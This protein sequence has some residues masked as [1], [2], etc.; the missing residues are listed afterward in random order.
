MGLQ[1]VR[2]GFI[3]AHDCIAQRLT[4]AT[5]RAP[6]CPSAPA[7][8][9]NDAASS[10]CAAFQGETVMNT[11]NRVGW[12]RLLASA[13]LATAPL[14]EALALSAADCT[15]LTG[16][17]VPGTTITSA[18]IL[19]AT[20]TAPEHCRVRGRVDAEI[21]FDLGLPTA[22]NGKF[23]HAGGGGF[24]GSIPSINGG[25]SRGYAAVATDTGHVGVG[26]AALDGSWALNRLDRQVNFGYRAIH[27]VTVAAKAI[28][29]H[30]Y[31]RDPNY[32]Y[33]EGCS[34]GGRQ[35][36][37]EAQRYPHDFDGIIAG[38]PALDWTGLMIG[39]NWD[40]QALR[41][42]P[43]PPAKLTLIA[44]AAAARCDAKDGLVDGLIGEPLRCDFNPA[45]LTCK[46]ADASDC[47]TAAQVRAVQKVYAGPTNSRGKQLHPGFAPGAED[48][49]S[50]WETWISGPTALGAPVNGNPLQ[51]TFQDHYLRF[52][53]FSNPA[54]DS[55][56]FDFDRDPRALRATGRF[57]NATNTDLSTLRHAGGKLI[58]WH[59]W[60]DH[61]LMAERTIQYY[62]EMADEIG[63]SRK[64]D[65]FARLYLA[66][67]MHHCAGGPGPNTFDMLTV[68]EKWVENHVSPGPVVAT[69]YVNDAP[70]QGVQRTRPLCPYPSV[71]RY[72][73]HGSIDDA[74][75]FR[76]GT[77]TNNRHGHDDD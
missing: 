7:Q 54:Y 51:F 41:A 40:S 29:R 16:L 1:H 60:S 74:A 61:A 6:D 11:R 53:V 45:V 72:V 31:G 38:A 24:V 22:W 10:E 67:G 4:S 46:G 12:I 25:L 35:A 39:F 23:Y 5:R 48:G 2:G 52:F 43:I 56:T 50:G 75:N 58:L 57:L 13:L 66:P 65:Q 71:A 9:Q 14:A 55:M 42:A 68:L 27:V 37:Q 59:G 69:K 17:S 70:A 32:A 8:L 73:G 76:C 33:F 77:R 19:A 36:M 44:Q 63:G 62:E 34:N 64:A 15:S 28:A 21:N 18:Q 30:A 26:V 47:L 49:G 20:T 3:D